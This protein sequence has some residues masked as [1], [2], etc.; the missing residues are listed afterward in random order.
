MADAYLGVTMNLKTSSSRSFVVISDCLELQR[1][2]QATLSAVYSR[3]R[4][5]AT[6]LRS[7]P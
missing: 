2:I 4:E 1:P 5:I 6:S 7:S 3:Q